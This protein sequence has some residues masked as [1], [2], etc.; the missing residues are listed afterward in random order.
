MNDYIL[1][2]DD[3][4]SPYIAHAFWNRKNQ[5]GSKRD[6]KYFQKIKEGLKTRYFYSKEEWDAYQRNKNSENEKRSDKSLN[7]KASK[8]I[9]EFKDK[10]SEKWNGGVSAKQYEEAHKK[11]VQAHRDLAATKRAIKEKEE[12]RNGDIVKYA[13]DHWTG[14]V[15][16]DKE[17]LERAQDRADRLD[18]HDAL[19]ERKAREAYQKSIVGKIVKGSAELLFDTLPDNSKW[20]NDY[21]ENQVANGESILSKPL[22]SLAYAYEANFD[23]AGYTDKEYMSNLELYKRRGYVEKKSKKPSNGHSTHYETQQLSYNSG[24]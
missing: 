3:N 24:K 10:V 12:A 18:K 11:T 21:L 15:Q 19:R 9:Q 14:E 1:A 23:P 16:K 5:N 7:S 22:I 2:F 13:K 6:F 8:Q 17:I 4:G 20:F